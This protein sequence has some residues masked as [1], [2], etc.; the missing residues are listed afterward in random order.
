MERS[1]EGR[2]GQPGYNPSRG[3]SSRG[4]LSRHSPRRQLV[5]FK[6]VREVPRQ[7]PGQGYTYPV[8][9]QSVSPRMPTADRQRQATLPTLPSPAVDVPPKADITYLPDGSGMEL[10][11]AMMIDLPLF[12]D[13]PFDPVFN[14]K[15]GLEGESSG[16]RSEGPNDHKPALKRARLA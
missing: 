7:M 2:H 5:A 4:L 9:Y 11:E 13:V 6:G 3:Q 16:R 10:P 15:R 12:D 1:K 8:D 14:R